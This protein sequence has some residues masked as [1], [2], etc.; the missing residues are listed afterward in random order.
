MG[1]LIRVL[2]EGGPM[3]GVRRVRDFTVAFALPGGV[4]ETVGKTEAGL[5]LLRWR[6]L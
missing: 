3:H 2:L 5:P 6:S 1:A 4:Y